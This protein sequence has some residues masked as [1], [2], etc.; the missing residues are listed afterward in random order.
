MLSE[1]LKSLLKLLVLVLVLAGIF[2][3]VGKFKSTWVSSDVN[4]LLAF[5]LIIT[6]GTT[7]LNTWAHR[8]KMLVNSFIATQVIRI[9]FCLILLYFLIS[10]NPNEANG[11]V[12]NFFIIYLVLLIFEISTLLS[13]LRSEITMPE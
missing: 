2:Y 6:A 8:N 12:V 7:V 13:N 9:L 4:L 5:L 3:V 11:L 1:I 10:S